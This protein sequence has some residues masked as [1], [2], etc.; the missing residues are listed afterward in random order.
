MLVPLLDFPEGNQTFSNP[1]SP[2]KTRD[3]TA[4]MAAARDFTR[5]Q[6]IVSIVR[7]VLRSFRVTCLPR[8]IRQIPSIVA[9]GWR[10]GRVAT[11]DTHRYVI[12]TCGVVEPMCRIHRIPIAR[13]IVYAPPVFL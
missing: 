11:M 5:Y 12:D 9:E 2:Q 6:E 13:C 8:Q 10:R 3:E 1:L 4:T 7:R